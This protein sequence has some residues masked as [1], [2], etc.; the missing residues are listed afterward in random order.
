MRTQPPRCCAAATRQGAG[1]YAE[2]RD[3]REKWSDMSI[4]ELTRV[5]NLGGSVLQDVALELHQV[6]A[7]WYTRANGEVVKSSVNPTTHVESVRTRKTPF[8][9]R[10][11]AGD[12]HMH[13]VDIR[14]VG[15]ERAGV[16]QEFCQHIILGEKEEAT[17]LEISRHHRSKGKDNVALLNNS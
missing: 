12:R 5:A 1:F 17:F 13:P 4:M 15:A 16:V 11:W 6:H 14:G 10:R 7:P 3:G 8:E 2:I 9:G